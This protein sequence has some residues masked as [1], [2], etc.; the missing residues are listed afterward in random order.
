[1]ALT[2]TLLRPTSARLSSAAG[3]DQRQSHLDQ[4][5][6]FY[7]KARALADAGQIDA[8][9]GLILKALDQERRAGSLGPQVI[10]LIKPRA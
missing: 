5:Q 2:S 4:A 8:S 9:A 7:A 1:L 6:L 3:V 10:Q